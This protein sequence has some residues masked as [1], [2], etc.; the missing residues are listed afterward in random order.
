MSKKKINSINKFKGEKMAIQISGGVQLSGPVLLD[1]T[2]GS[3]SGGASDGYVSGGS[4][5]LAPH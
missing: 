5:V 3:E 1:P 2:G 4:Q